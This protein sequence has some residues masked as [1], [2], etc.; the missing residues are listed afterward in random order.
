MEALHGPGNLCRLQI[1]IKQQAFTLDHRWQREMEAL[2]GRGNLDR[3]QIAIKQ[4]AFT[5]NHTTPFDNNVLLSDN[6]CMCS[7]VSTT[8]VEAIY[9][10]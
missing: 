1:A 6:N 10:T 7:Q 3:L 9:K 2:H 5:M 4:Q 8:V